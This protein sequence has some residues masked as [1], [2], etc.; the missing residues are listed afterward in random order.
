MEKDIFTKVK[1]MH[2]ISSPE[3]VP[4]KD[5]T[6]VTEEEAKKIWNKYLNDCIIKAVDGA[7]HYIMFT[8]FQWGLT[9]PFTGIKTGGKSFDEDI[10]LLHACIVTKGTPSNIMIR[11]GS[12]ASKQDIKDAKKLDAEWRK[13]NL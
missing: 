13:N 12:I 4:I 11:E 8:A 6:G 1:I 3:D 10:I 7:E 5:Y 2:R 9:N